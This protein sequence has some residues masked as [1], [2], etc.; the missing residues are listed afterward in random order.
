M[1]DE[2]RRQ[3]GARRELSE[4]MSSPC[5]PSL[6]PL[7]ACQTC[8]ACLTKQPP[9]ACPC[10]SLRGHGAW[11]GT[12]AAPPLFPL[13]LRGHFTNACSA[14]PCRCWDNMHHWEQQWSWPTPTPPPPKQSNVV[15]GTYQKRAWYGAQ[16]V[17][18]SEA[19]ELDVSLSN[20]RRHCLP[21]AS[22]AGIILELRMEKGSAS[23]SIA[24]KSRVLR[25]GEFLSR[26]G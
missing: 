12:K 22:L 10:P 21:R 26:P 4:E 11:Q 14:S 24:K 18:M 3:T 25:S 8:P 20:R 6:Q 17:F 2:M 13:I 23:C 1:E 9:S 16:W 5:L 15:D 19:G 7:H